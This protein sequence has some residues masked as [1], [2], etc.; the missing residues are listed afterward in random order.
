MLT[1]YGHLAI[2]GDVDHYTEKI[3]RR[4]IDASN[5]IT[6]E[7]IDETASIIVTNGQTDKDKVLQ[8]GNE[9]II[10]VGNLL[11]SMSM[12]PYEGNEEEYAQYD[13]KFTVLN[14]KNQIKAW[15]TF[16]GEKCRVRVNANK[17]TYYTI[18]DTSTYN[19][20]IEFAKSLV[21]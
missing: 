16:K 10:Y 8:N 21:N 14:R 12:I 7:Y 9:N 13:Y 3:V 15:Y 6:E 11:Q 5:G 4:N 20:L 19:E 2:I 18:D 17:I 1:L